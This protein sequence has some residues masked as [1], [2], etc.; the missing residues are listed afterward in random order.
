[1]TETI[2][3]LDA[4]RIDNRIREFNVLDTVKQASTCWKVTCF[5]VQEAQR[6]HS[7]VVQVLPPEWAVFQIP[8]G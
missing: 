3:G 7:F 8:M 5:G 4:S 2:L 1:M 6:S